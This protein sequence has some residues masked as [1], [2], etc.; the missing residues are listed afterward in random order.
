LFAENNHNI[1]KL[2]DEYHKVFQLVLSNN[3]KKADRKE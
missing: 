3:D 1:S 2:A